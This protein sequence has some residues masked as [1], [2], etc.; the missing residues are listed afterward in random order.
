MARYTMATSAAEG[1]AGLVGIFEYVNRDGRLWRWNCGQAAAATMLAHHRLG[2]VAG[3]GSETMSELERSFPPD[4][5][6]GWFGSSRRRVVSLCKAHGLPLC[7]VRGEAE[8][9]RTLADRRPAIVM[10]GVPGARLG[11]WRLPGGH[12]MV[13]YA[14]D[15]R[16]IHLTNWPEPMPWP[17]FRAG[18]TSFVSRL[19]QMD[20]RGLCESPDRLPMPAYRGSGSLRTNS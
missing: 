1:F 4:I 6:G 7:D 5:L 2:P 20:E 8:L 19:I 10:L 9:R 18:W 16:H 14:F 3:H 15:D 11:P 13:A 12:W 17:E